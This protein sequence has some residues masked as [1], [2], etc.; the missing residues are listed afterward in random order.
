MSLLS[1]ERH[2]FQFQQKSEVLFDG[3]RKLDNQSVIVEGDRI[4]DVVPGKKGADFQ[5]YVTPAFID[6]HS[7]IGMDREGEPWTESETND[8]LNQILPVN[9]PLN[10]IYFDDRAFRDAVDF[11]ILYSCIVPGSGNLLGGKAKVIRNFSSR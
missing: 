7:H 10:S 4:V 1:G 8:T 6:A 9:D 5:G 3:H 11:G 2:P